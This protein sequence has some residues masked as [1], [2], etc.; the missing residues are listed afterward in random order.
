M[1]Q[2]LSNN[3]TLEQHT[4]LAA[5][6]DDRLLQVVISMRRIGPRAM[7]RSGSSHRPQQASP[8]NNPP[9]GIFWRSISPPPPPPPPP[10]TPVPPSPPPPPPFIAELEDTSPPRAAA[11]SL[12]SAPPVIDVYIPSPNLS[13]FLFTAAAAAAAAADIDASP[14][15]FPQSST[16]S[17]TQQFLDTAATATATTSSRGSPAAPAGGGSPVHA[18]SPVVWPFQDADG[19]D[20]CETPP[21]PYTALDEGSPPA[22]WLPWDETPAYCDCDCDCGCDCDSDSDSDSD[23]ASDL[24]SFQRSGD[25]STA[26]RLRRRRLRFFHWAPAA[27]LLRHES[28]YEHGAP[29]ILSVRRDLLS[30][31]DETSTRTSSASAP[32]RRAPSR[33]RRRRM[34]GQTVGSAYIAEGGS[35]SDDF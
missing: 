30:G 18:A 13:T 3:F 26:R 28:S 25:E 33:W 31:D 14:V 23:L 24:D 9:R 10:A 8:V 5:Q 17:T 29:D 27:P 34:A 11:Y 35:R 6:L 20:D 32:R 19:D 1:S 22:L 2:T 4:N 16:P 15:L 21:P 12:G 7:H